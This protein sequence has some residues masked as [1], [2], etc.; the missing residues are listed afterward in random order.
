M[1]TGDTVSS[2]VLTTQYN[3]NGI[4]PGIFVAIDDEEMYVFTTNP[5]TN[6][7]IVS[8][9]EN[10]TTPVYHGSGARIYVNEPFNRNMILNAI[11]DDIRSWGPQVYQVKTADITAVAYQRGYDLGA[12][13]PYYNVMEVVTT[14]YPSFALN[15]NK[16]W[17]RVRF[18]DFQSAPTTDF[19]SGNALIIDGDGGMQGGDMTYWNIGG[20]TTSIHVTYAAAFN[21][22]AILTGGEATLLGATVGLD[23]TDFDI[24]ALGAAWRLMMM[25]EARRATQLM[26]GEPRVESEIPPLYI[27]KAAEQFK[28]LRDGRLNDAQ[29]RLIRMYG[30]KST[31]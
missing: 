8:R 23:E 30:M 27:S 13:T 16:D 28:I 14:P 22:D 10:S 2:T 19:P 21:A 24:P 31:P 25:R 6:T 26:Q 4:T 20:V 12:I 29:Y 15:D 17:K 5:G 7:A 3:L 11:V 18:H 1:A 9:G